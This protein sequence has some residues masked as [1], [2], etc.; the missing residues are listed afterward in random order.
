MNEN[1]IMPEE[2]YCPCC[3]YG[4]IYYPEDGDGTFCEWICTREENEEC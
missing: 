3:P 4:Y 1:C 2:P